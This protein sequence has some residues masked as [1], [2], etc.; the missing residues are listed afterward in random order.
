MKHE[1]VAV[2]VCYVCVPLLY[3]L[4]LPALAEFDPFGRGTFAIGGRLDGVTS[5][6]WYPPD[7]S[8][9]ISR[10]VQTGA[11]GG[12]FAAT[13]APAINYVWTNKLSRAKRTIG[14]VIGATL[15]TAGWFALIVLPVSFGSHEAHAL[16]WAVFLLGY[17]IHAVASLFVL[18]PCRFA[19]AYVV[20]SL[21]LVAGSSFLYFAHSLVWLIVQFV[22]AAVVLIH[23]PL[24][25]TIAHP[26]E[27]S[28]QPRSCWTRLACCRAL[29]VVPIGASCPG[30]ASGDG[31]ALDG[32]SSALGHAV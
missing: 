13:T 29:L 16:A 28:H 10:F 22:V 14:M 2:W 11:A 32:E 27:T 17:A 6:T 21:P 31:A 7:D 1:L 12:A 26:G 20:A 30:P 3:L 23:T 19:T 25:N 24:L 18:A 4:L 5:F 15:L 9:S 8:V